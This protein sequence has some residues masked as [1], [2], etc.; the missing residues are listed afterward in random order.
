MS[1]TSLTLSVM[2][3]AA[4]DHHARVRRASLRG[5]SISEVKLRG[6][7]PGPPASSRFAAKLSP[8]LQA[9]CTMKRKVQRG[10]AV[11]GAL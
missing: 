7:L 11:G 1:L 3:A 4:H 6:Q 5:L 8:P 2:C 9:V 10:A